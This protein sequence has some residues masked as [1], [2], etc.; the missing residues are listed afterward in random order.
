MSLSLY[1]KKINT[2]H[3]YF[4]NWERNCLD[5]WWH[6]KS[7]FAVIFRC[8]ISNCSIMYGIF[9]LFFPFLSFFLFTFFWGGFITLYINLCRSFQFVFAIFGPFLLSSHKIVDA[10]PINLTYIPLVLVCNTNSNVS[11]LFGDKA[12]KLS[13]AYCLHCCCCGY[14]FCCSCKNLI[15][16]IPCNCHGNV[17]VVNIRKKTFSP[18]CVNLNYKLGKPS[19]CK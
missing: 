6:F 10:F 12:M 13:D 16:E 14:Y 9:H 17:A 3:L 5:V 11:I 7:R 1:I 2:F 18:C 8:I 15:Q 4:S 19:S